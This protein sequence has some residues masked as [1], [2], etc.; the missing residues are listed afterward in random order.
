MKIP[1][2]TILGRGKHIAL[3]SLLALAMCLTACTADSP[4]VATKPPMSPVGHPWLSG[5]WLGGAMD[6]EVVH[7]FG[8]WRGS[9]AEVLTTYPAYKTWDEI[10]ESNWHVATY[11]GFRGR[12]AYGLPLLPRRQAATLAEVAA[13]EHDQVWRDVANTL[14]RNGRERTFVRIGLEANGHWF[15]WGANADTAADF[16][17]AYRHVAQ[18][19]KAVAPRLVFVFDITCGESLRGAEDDRLA[20]LTRLYPGDDV[21]DVIGCDRYDSW[22]QIARTEKEW[23]ATLRPPDAAG[24]IDVVEFAKKHDKQFA[25]PEWGIVSTD[26]NGTGDNP[27]FMA[28]MH[29]FFWAHR[30]QL[31]F[32]NYFDEPGP[33][34]GSSLF[35]KAQNPDS[36]SIY[37]KLW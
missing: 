27:F 13:G 29:Q 37:Q 31:A 21:V 35:L 11:D 9:D 18:V 15:P 14:L 8:E 3:I 22:G 32:E 25:V 6:A 36:A 33:S 28:K 20:S 24:M 30:D 19:M 10:S 26:N 17:A 2:H 34:L 16:Q 1:P 12:L 23:Q 5:I 7:E 4:S